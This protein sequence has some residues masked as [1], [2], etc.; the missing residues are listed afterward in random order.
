METGFLHYRKILQFRFSFS[1]AGLSEEQ[2]SGVSSNTG[3]VIGLSFLLVI[4]LLILAQMYKNHQRVKKIFFWKL[5]S[6]IYFRN[7]KNTSKS[8]FL[9]WKQFLFLLFGFT[10]S[11]KVFQLSQM[12]LQIL[13][14]C[15]LFPLINA[16]YLFPTEKENLAV[17]C[18]GNHRSHHLQRARGERKDTSEKVKKTYQLK[19][20]LP[21]DFP[22][23]T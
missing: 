5:C 2:S 1:L 20:F 18:I 11:S 6:N 15:Q 12:H 4:L 19:E 7:A 8:K 9:T 10:G 14:R 17:P 13:L 22:N 3:T 16:Y 23:A 21:E